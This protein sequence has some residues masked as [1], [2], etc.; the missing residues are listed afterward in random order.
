[1]IYLSHSKEMN[2]NNIVRQIT[3]YIKI[4]PEKK[5]E[6][7]LWTVIAVATLWRFL[8]PFYVNPINNIWS[9]PKRHYLHALGMGKSTLSFL[10]PLGYQ[11]W[12]S[13]IFKLVG[14]QPLEIALYAGVLSAI[15]PWIW[16]Q[17]LAECLPSKNAALIGYA[18]LACL[19]SWIAI[20]S[21]FMPETLLLPLLGLA[22]WTSWWAK[23]KDTY[24][25]YIGAAFTW[26][27]AIATKLTVLPQ[28]FVV[29]IWLLLHLLKH[30]RKRQVL[31]ITASCSSI[32]FMMYLAGPIY[33]YI[34]L[35]DFWLFPPGWARPNQK[36]CESGA[37]TFTFVGIGKNGATE[38]SRILCPSV[39]HP[40]HPFG[41]KSKRVGHSYVTIDFNEP[42]QLI[43]P[44]TQMSISNL[45]D[46]TAENAVYF[47]SSAAWPECEKKDLISQWGVAMR[48]IWFPLT[49]IV[50]FLVARTKRVTVIEIIF[51]TTILA[52][53]FQH[54][55]VMEGRYRKPWEG[56]AVAALISTSLL[57]MAWFNKG[58]ETNAT[59]PIKR[60]N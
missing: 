13:T 22:L 54:M 53:L 35:K 52:N 58:R 23:R 4:K 39:V 34:G 6:T 37:R 59:S 8:Y 36:Y 19:P 27:C 24:V 25:A 29:S 56:L 5:W 11:I 3:T 26:G 32:I 57:L 28:L 30:K 45:L 33:T 9:D 42:T 38:V 7:I 49:M 10:D 21:Y 20:Y 14:T 40:D 41:W 15:T 48:W 16:Y 44:G 51:F 47:F 2:F 12:L 31:L 55:A 18:I 17:W 43:V 50:L 1:M 60:L 46:L